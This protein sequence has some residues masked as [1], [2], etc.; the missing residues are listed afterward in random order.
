MLNIVANNL[1]TLNKAKPWQ[2][3]LQL[4]PGP[5]CI[6]SPWPGPTAQIQD[7]IARMEEFKPGE[8]SE[9]WSFGVSKLTDKEVV[10]V[11]DMDTCCICIDY[12]C[13]CH[14]LKMEIHAF[15]LPIQV[16]K[17]AFS[18]DVF[19]PCKKRVGVW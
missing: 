10:T 13:R 2:I 4:R 9:G 6:Q 17:G 14:C 8:G 19:I 18:S 16:P 7:L 3:L 15:I 1:P 5:R 12:D 11:V